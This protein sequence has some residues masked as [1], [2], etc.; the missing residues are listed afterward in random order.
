MIAYCSLLIIKIMPPPL[1]L[2]ELTHL[3]PSG[4]LLARSGREPS[5]EGQS[6]HPL[7]LL[8]LLLLLLFRG[9]V[10]VISCPSLYGGVVDYHTYIPT[11]VLLPFA[12]LVRSISLCLLPLP[13]VFL[14]PPPSQQLQMSTKSFCQRRRKTCRRYLRHMRM[15]FKTQRG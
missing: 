8:L 15:P 6:K 9:G 10:F 3:A 5:E 13:L 14:P 4:S 1:F 11:P 7:L 12:F 2:S